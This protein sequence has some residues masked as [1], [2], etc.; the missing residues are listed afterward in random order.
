[1]LALALVGPRVVGGVGVRVVSASM[2]KTF[3]C[4]GTHDTVHQYRGEYRGLSSSVR[5]APQ[6][7]NAGYRQ[8][9]G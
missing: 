2:R 7:P 4:A 6:R 9:E 8:D 5:Y 3:V 1:M